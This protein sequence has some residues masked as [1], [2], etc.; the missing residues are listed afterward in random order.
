MD[1]LVDENITSRKFPYLIKSLP[2]FEEIVGF[3][4]DSYQECTKEEK[5]NIMK[6]KELLVKIGNIS[7]ELVKGNMTYHSLDLFNQG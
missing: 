4:A 2:K 5:V 1:L 3:V 7:T 6:V